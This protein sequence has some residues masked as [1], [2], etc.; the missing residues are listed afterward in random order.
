MDGHDNSDVGVLMVIAIGTLF[1]FYL[2]WAAMHDIAHGESDCTL[3]Y[4]VLV[5]SIPAFAFLYRT[6]LLHLAPRAKAAW[7][8]GTG[9]LILLFDL[10]ALSAKLHPKYAPDRMLAS[11]FLT[12]GVPVFG[13]I[14]YHLVRETLRLRARLRS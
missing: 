10:A 1:V 2:V 4:A 12:A 5:I 8:G 9:L 3:E 6:A 14:S 11:L 7:L 13:L